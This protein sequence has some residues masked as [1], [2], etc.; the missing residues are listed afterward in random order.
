MKTHNNLQFSGLERIGKERG[1]RVTDEGVFLGVNNNVLINKNKGY[2]CVYIKV[3]G[4]T[5]VL[6]AHR[7]QA[8]QKYGDAIYN[9][10]ICVRH[11]NSDKGDNSYSNISIGTNR[12]NMMD[13]PKSERHRI[14]AL[15]G[16][17]TIKYNRDEVVEYY[18][19][20][21]RSRKRTINH[22]GMSEAGLHY[23]LNNRKYNSR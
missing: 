13:K 22:F 14:G 17:A 9:N 19:E 6:F 15:A 23:I 12:D 4:K 2:P 16:K 10:G 7:L 18:N 11:L 21:D 5:K 8:Y 1:Y 20:C 3:N